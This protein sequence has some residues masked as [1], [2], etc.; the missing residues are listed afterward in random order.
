M[1]TNHPEAQWFKGA[2]FGIFIHW[3]I[4]S[5][6][7]IEISWPIQPHHR[8]HID[9]DEYEALAY[10]FKAENYNP[11]EWAKIAKEAGAR[12]AVLTTKHHDGYCLFD[13]ST[14]DYS[15]AKTGPGRD[16]VKPY[17]EAFRNAGLKVGLYFSLIDWHDPDFATIP[18]RQEIA[19]PKPY[20]YDPARWNN[21]LVRVYEQIK[22]LLTNYGRIDLFWFDVAGFGADRW[23]SSELYTMMLNLQPHLVIN[24]RL[25]GVGDYTTPE[26]R[27]PL[28]PPSGWWETCMTMNNQWSYHPDPA[29]YKSSRMLIRILAQVAGMGGNLLLNVGP[30]P[31]GTFPDE[32]VERLKTIG[33]WMSHSSEAIYDTEPGPDP[34]CFYGPMTRRGNTLYLH[35]FDPPKEEIEV[36]GIDGHIEQA[37]LLKTGEELKVY[38]QIGRIYIDLPEEK[39]DEY[40]TVVAL[41][42]KEEPRLRD[43]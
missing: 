6:R 35:V 38:K 18:I 37:Y 9:V 11:E 26:Q 4:S 8:Q 14:T 23:K 17:V 42:F 21:F 5:V 34:A 3:G 27:V 22:E 30:K 28:R 43:R 24:N 2:R 19:S 1:P 10:E 15:A 31:D 13:T 16:L 7:A 33:S 12:Y 20:K 39:C 41:K 36:R 40:N 32:A 25:P 29:Q